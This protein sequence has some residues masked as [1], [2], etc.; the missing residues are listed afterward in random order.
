[1]SIYADTQL[2]GTKT[3]NTILQSSNLKNNS[4]EIESFSN[5]M[6]LAVTN[7]SN[8][9]LAGL[10]TNAAYLSEITGTPVNDTLNGTSEQDTINAGDG[11]DIVNGYEGNDYING[12][13]GNDTLIGGIGADTMMGGIGSDTYYVDNAGDVITETPNGDKYAN[14]TPLDT[15]WITSTYLKDIYARTFPR[16]MGNQWHVVSDGLFEASTRYMYVNGVK[17]VDWNATQQAN[18]KLLNIIANYI[19]YVNVNRAGVRD[20]QGLN[21]FNDLFLDNYDSIF[22]PEKGLLKTKNDIYSAAELIDKRVY[23]V[24]YLNISDVWYYQSATRFPEWKFWHS[25]ELFNGQNFGSWDYAKNNNLFLTVNGEILHYKGGSDST[26]PLFDA[27]NPLWQQYY[28]D[29]VKGILDAGFDGIMSDNWIRSQWTGDLYKLPADQFVKLQQGWN[30]AGSL[31]QQMIGPD[32]FLIGNS[33]AYDPFT[34]RDVCFLEDRIDD[35]V[36]TG[37]KSIAAYFRY[38]DLARN[39]NQVCQ[40]TYWDESRG[41]FET[42]RLPINLL[43]NNILGVGSATDRNTSVETFFKPVMTLGDIG[44][45]LGEKEIVSG[46]AT[47]VRDIISNY[48]VQ[49]AVY[50]RYFTDGVVYLNASDRRQ[51]I[52]L[53]QGEW[54]RSDG[55][56]FKGGS[57]IL[58]DPCR[59][60]VFRNNDNDIVDLDVDKVFSGITYTLGVYLEDLELTGIGDINAYGNNLDNSLTGNSGN[61]IIEGKDGNDTLIGNQGN[62]Q[63]NGENGDDEY[64]FN[65]GDGQDIITDTKGS[66]SIKLGTGL[67]RYDLLF[68]RD[69]DNVVIEFRNSTDKLTINNW[70]YQDETSEHKIEKL[71]FSDNSYFTSIDIENL[72]NKS[73]IYGT[74]DNDTINGTA[75]DNRIESFTGMDSINAGAGNDLIFAG[76]NDDTI[77]SDAGFDTMYGGSGNDTYEWNTGDGQDIIQDESGTDALRFGAGINQASLKF[78][79]NGN[80]V[81]IS[82]NNTTEKITINDWYTGN[83][84]ESLEFFDGTKLSATEVEAII[85]TPTQP[86]IIP[87]IIGTDLNNYYYRSSYTDDIYYAKKGNDQYYDYQGND[88]YLFN[89]GDGQ[90]RLTDTTGSDRIVFGE[91]I[92]Q[93][94]LRYSVVYGS[95]LQVGITGTNDLIN[96]IDW[97]RS[98]KFVVEKFEFR[99]GTFLTS[100]QINQLV[101]QINTYSASS[102]AQIG[103]SETIQNQS[104]AELV[105][106]N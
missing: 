4:D 89:R 70:F 18:Q 8:I 64:R 87:T 2:I 68:N 3:S 106:N 52:T 75:G 86:P 34:S 36:G 20:G 63:I 12:G 90:D 45:P 100:T 81:I 59:G 23:V 74:L 24:P 50:A 41:P 10:S 28:A 85:S 104:T 31:I 37:D 76:E 6:F 96:I 32:K 71:I 72:A 102:A 35:V 60:W 49:R 47:G 83:R 65:K 14:A 82:L 42:F 54:L 40:D 55:T 44:I 7:S 95:S 66:D 91:G 97:F 80:N 21:G 51:Y 99:D 25:Q 5:G 62:D 58:L 84:I 38:S 57:S 13:K 33:P 78:E 105:F 39:M 29:H 94:D 11:N 17:K 88:T 48:S 73:I 22:N 53:P 43:T 77:R 19:D 46:T 92:S 15:S 93:S 9:K 61:N 56:I 30:N 67:T 103:F 98:P 1:M 101:Q 16:V 26:R 79:R 69:N 27:R